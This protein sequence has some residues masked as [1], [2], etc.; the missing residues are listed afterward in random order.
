[1]E[2]VDCGH[3]LDQEE[4]EAHGIYEIISY[5]FYMDGMV[6]MHLI[7]MPIKKIAEL[8]DDVVDDRLSSSLY[9]VC[10]GCGIHE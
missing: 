1:M 5:P 10:D 6:D 3:P 4:I 2:C 9:Y 8:P 7:E